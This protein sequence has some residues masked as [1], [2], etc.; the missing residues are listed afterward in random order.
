M[1][2]A[3]GDLHTSS[4]TALCP[5]KTQLDSGGYYYANAFQLYLWDCWRDMWKQLRKKAKTHGVSITTVVLGDTLDKNKYSKNGV[6][7]HNPNNMLQAAARVL[8]P[9]IKASER[10][11]IVRGT[12]AHEGE[13]AWLAEAL[14]ERIGAA[15]AAKHNWSWW[16][17]PLEVSGVGF[18]IKH[19]P[20]SGDMRPWTAGGGM[21]R[22]AAS[23][24]MNYVDSGDMPPK[25]ALRGHRHQWRDSGT[26]LPTR[27]FT[28]PA[29]QG[30]TDFVHRIGA[31]GTQIPKFGCAWFL[32][33][34]GDYEWGRI[35]YQPDRPAMETI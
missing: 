11:Y 8:K 20:E 10:V 21:I 27:A 30:P 24:I 4:V 15:K 14:A 13:E 35:M 3:V 32:C 19:H 1:L 5:P 23:V 26:N 17:L 2:V 9:A 31:G 34:D 16:H 22:V 12:P 18:D 25:I 29:W 7:A 6:F 33:D 28:I